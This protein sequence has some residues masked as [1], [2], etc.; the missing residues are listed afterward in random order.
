MRKLAIV[1]IVV[2]I[3]VIVGANWTISRLPAPPTPNEADGAT[4]RST[5]S[6]DVVGFIDAS[7]ARAWLGIPFA[8]PPVGALRW[9]A[10]QPPVPAEGT[11]EALAFGAMCPQLPSLLSDASQSP[12]SAEEAAAV[13]AAVAGSEDC[14]MLNIWSPPNASGLPVMLWIHGGGNSIG[15]GGNVNGGNLAVGGNVVVVSINY[16]LGLF[17][18]FNHPGLHAG[19]PANDSGNYGTLDMIRALEWTRDN[20][21]AFGGDP[22]NVTVFGESAGA[23]NTL[24]MMASPL[25]EGLFHRAAVQS[26]GYGVSSLASGQNYQDHGGHQYS[27]PEVLNALLVADGKAADADAARAIQDGWTPAETRNYLYAKTPADIYGLLDGGGFGMVNVPNNFKDGHVLP[28]LDAEDL[29]S[30]TGNYNAVPVILGTNRDEPTLFM[31]RDPR[32]VDNLFGIFYSLKDEDA[33]RREVRY[34]ARAWKARGVDELAQFMA[35]SGH[36]NVYAYRWD[37]DEEPSALGYDLSVALGAAHAL[38]IAFVFNDFEGGIAALG[39]IYPN[40]ENQSALSR[41]MMSYWTEFAYAGAPGRG[42][43]G[44][45]VPWLAWGQGGQTSILLDTP[46]D[47]GIRMDDDVVT[48]ASV[49]AELMADASLPPGRERCE[50]YVRLFRWQGLFD[51]GEYRSLGC[52]AYPAESFASF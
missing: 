20:I 21:A 47:G 12:Q 8:R 40:D 11:I 22:G 5:E 25:A 37:W 13:A 17:G 29:F 18:W 35:A 9:Q 41:S 15:H 24:A 26:G 36:P 23:F 49:K 32:Y 16:R 42:R 39:Y 46:T 48:S 4:L 6:G 31:S 38:E 2:A 34:S 52:A 44:A 43:D 33:Y 30:D 45:E 1:L 14:L 51:D 28:T 19:D 3:A 50:L 7:G 10:P 27:A